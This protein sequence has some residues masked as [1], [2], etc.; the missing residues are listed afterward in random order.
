ARMIRIEGRGATYGDVWFDEQPDCGVDIVR[1]HSRPTPVRDARRTPFLSMVTD[2]GVDAESLT[3][4]FGKDCRYKIRRADTKDELATEWI[5]NPAE[6]LE[7]FRAFFDTFASQKGHEPCD[8]QWL[9]AA[10]N[11]GQLVLTNAFRHDEAL[12]WHAYVVAG[13][14]TWLQYTGSCYR[15][16]DNDYRALVGRA[17]RWLHWKDMLRFKDQGMT[18][19][20]W[21]GLFQDESAP[22]RAGINEFK[23]SFGGQIVQSFDCI[24]PV[25]LRGRIV[26]P[27]RDAWRNRWAVLPGGKESAAA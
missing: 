13:K 25:T 14:S 16:R 19:Y 5:T 7:E 18:R 4:G 22:D 27:L 20:D 2:L 11:A 24:V 8:L 17:N 10:C 9:R 21:G 6:R 15:D 12:V 23:K 3:A 26:L 1:Y